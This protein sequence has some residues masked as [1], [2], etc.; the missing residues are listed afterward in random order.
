LVVFEKNKPQKIFEPK[1]RD[2]GEFEIKTNEELRGLF[3][4]VNIIGNHEK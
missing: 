1:K 2:E 4:E 3:G